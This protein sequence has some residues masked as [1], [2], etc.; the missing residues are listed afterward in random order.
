[1]K[2]ETILL[3]TLHQATANAQKRPKVKSES[4]TAIISN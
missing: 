2:I 4:F 3:I 1:M